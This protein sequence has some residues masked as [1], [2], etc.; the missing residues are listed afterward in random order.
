VLS[1]TKRKG[2]TQEG[3]EEKRTLKRKE[4]PKVEGGRKRIRWRVTHLFY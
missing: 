4:T 2:R 3:K 1:V